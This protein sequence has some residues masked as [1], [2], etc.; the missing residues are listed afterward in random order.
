[1]AAAVGATRTTKMQRDI[2]QGIMNRRVRALPMACV[3]L[4]GAFLS[5]PC[6]GQ[7]VG[8][9]PGATPQYEPATQPDAKPPTGKSAAAAP[10]PKSPDAAH[11][12]SGISKEPPSIPADQIIQQF[13]Q[14]EVEFKT[15]REN[16]TYVQ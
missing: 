2:S 11:R 9:M 5:I 10:V 14:H 1:M 13:A 12:S 7:E 3:L 8:P 16:F 4:A 15:E 6:A